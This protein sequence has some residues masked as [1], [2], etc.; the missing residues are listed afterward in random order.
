MDLRPPRS[1]VSHPFRRYEA[2]RRVALVSRINRKA[3]RAG[4]CASLAVRPRDFRV[5]NMDKGWRCRH[6]S[7]SRVKQP[8][9]SARPLSKDQ[10]DP[11]SRLPALVPVTLSSLMYGPGPCHR[12]SVPVR[13]LRTDDVPK[14]VATSREIRSCACG[15]SRSSRSRSAAACSR[16]LWSASVTT[17]GR[18]ESLRSGSARA[19]AYRRRSRTGRRWQLRRWP[20]GL[21]TGCAPAGLR[22]GCAPAGL[23]TGCAPA[24]RRLQ[25][26]DEVGPVEVPVRHVAQPLETAQGLERH[27]RRVTVADAKLDLR[28]DGCSEWLP[29]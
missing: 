14:K 11:V 26:H 12:A 28:H 4:A 18:S 10:I 3:G 7:S 16:R 19:S 22:T 20:A 29:R 15:A 5:R 1:G 13:H 25:V 2:V 21:R 23:R 17:A 9:H 27:A 8:V 6:W 24:H